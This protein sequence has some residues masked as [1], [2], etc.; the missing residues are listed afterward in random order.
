MCHAPPEIAKA[1][2]MADR[3]GMDTYRLS[4]YP[5]KLGDPR[6]RLSRIT[7]E[8]WVRAE[9]SGQARSKVANATMAVSAPLGRSPWYDEAFTRCVVDAA[10]DDVPDH[11]VV[12]SGGQH[13]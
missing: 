11:G 13:L 1:S 8:A 7:E 9:T 6:W 12:T 10:R 5:G 2:P 3:R 4:P